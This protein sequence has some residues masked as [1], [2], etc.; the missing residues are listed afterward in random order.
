LASMPPRAI[1]RYNWRP[2][3][4]TAE[5]RLYE[6]FLPAKDWLASAG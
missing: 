5:A 3:K 2:E 1:W 4:G 6:D